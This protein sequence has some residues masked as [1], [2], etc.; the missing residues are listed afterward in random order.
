MTHLSPQEQAA[1]KPYIRTLADRLGLRDWTITLCDEPADSDAWAS[2]KPIE[3]RKLAELHLCKDW[4][5]L[6]PETKRHALVHELIHCTHAGAADMVRLDL[7]RWMGQAAYDVF[8][9]GWRRQMEYMVDGLAEVLG[10]LM[11]DYPAVK[12]SKK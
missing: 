10:P 2:I 9:G 6:K 7:P 12:P 3:G 11:P 1:I 8:F 5:T 4:Y